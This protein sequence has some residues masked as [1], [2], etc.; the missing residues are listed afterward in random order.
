VD[1]AILFHKKSMW[2]TF[3]SQTFYIV[4]SEPAFQNSIFC[5]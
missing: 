1:K 5:F 3:F 2:M 4:H